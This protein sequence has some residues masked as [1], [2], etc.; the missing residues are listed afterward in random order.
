MCGPNS[1]AKEKAEAFECGAEPVQ[2]AVRGTFPGT[3][4]WAD[5]YKVN[6]NNATRS[7]AYMIWDN[8]DGGDREEES[9]MCAYSQPKALLQDETAFVCTVILVDLHGRQKKSAA[10]GEWR[11]GRNLNC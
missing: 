7:I 3:Q 6:C 1:S 11:H 8:K 2:T 4:K 9:W 5:S 10:K